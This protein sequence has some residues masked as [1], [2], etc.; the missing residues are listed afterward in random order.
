MTNTSSEQKTQRKSFST[1]KFKRRYCELMISSAV[2]SSVIYLLNIL[3]VF[4]THASLYT[5]MII[6]TL[7]FMIYNVK[8][9]RDSRAKL[10]R[11]NVYYITNFAAYF[12]FVITGVIIYLGVI[13]FNGTLKVI[14]K[15]VYTFLFAITKMLKLIDPG[16]SMRYSWLLFHSIGILCI[17]AGRIK[18]SDSAP[19]KVN[20]LAGRK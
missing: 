5:V 8:G 4:V 20:I 12:A 1:T 11:K 6:G 13:Y 2:I 18:S 7:L 9:C 16:T 19:K 15:E 14:A 10:R 17:F 3:D